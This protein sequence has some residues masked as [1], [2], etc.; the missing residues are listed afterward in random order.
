MQY[1]SDEQLKEV[2]EEVVRNFLI[3]KFIDLGMNASG[4]WLES[5][6]VEALEGTGYIKGQYYSY[7]LAHG[8]ANGKNPPI[9][10]LI[11]WVGHKMGLSGEEAKRAAYAISNKIAKEGTDY[12]PS[13]TDLLTV[14][15]SPEVTQY[16]YTRLGGIARGNVRTEIMKRVKQT[17]IVE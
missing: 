7:W 9:Q 10:P 3:P 17:I 8:R 1:V 13:G 4:K 12:Y 6:A 11:D 5:L 15:S 14:L 16:V 2:L